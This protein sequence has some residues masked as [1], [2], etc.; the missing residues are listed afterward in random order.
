MNSKYTQR[1]IDD[2]E[3]Y[4][5]LKESLE[6]LIKEKE[7]QISR[8]VNDNHNL[9]KY[10]GAYEDIAE[11]LQKHDPKGCNCLLAVVTCKIRAEKHMKQLR[12]SQR[13]IGEVSKLRNNLRE[14]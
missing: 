7:R 13:D 11:V 4:E 6:S 10:K 8:L 3:K 9:V 12:Q 5:L 2:E 1:Q 14:A